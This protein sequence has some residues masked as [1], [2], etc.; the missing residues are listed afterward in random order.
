[1]LV[2]CGGDEGVSNGLCKRLGPDL[3]GVHTDGY[4]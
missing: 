1:M 3:T 4:V 2:A